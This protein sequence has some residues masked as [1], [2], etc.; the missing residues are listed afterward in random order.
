[1][2]TYISG[3]RIRSRDGASVRCKC[4]GQVMVDAEGYHQIPI[5]FGFRGGKFV[6]DTVRQRGWFGVC[7]KCRHDVFAP[8]QKAR[9]ATRI[10]RAINQKI[11]RARA[12]LG[13]ET[14]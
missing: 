1:M 9:V 10:P 12:R 8:N 14:E 4:G 5:G 2:K 11:K 13:R 7:L 6:V 3:Q